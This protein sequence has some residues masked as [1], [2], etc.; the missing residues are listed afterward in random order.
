VFLTLF[1]KDILMG[2]L[3]RIT[4]AVTGNSDSASSGAGDTQ[5]SSKDGAPTSQT[6]SGP[7]ADAP[8]QSEAEK[9]AEGQFE[10]SRFRN[11]FRRI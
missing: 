1:F 9:A 6:A 5:S 2:I 3:G 4:S 11:G 10:G 8:G 7:L